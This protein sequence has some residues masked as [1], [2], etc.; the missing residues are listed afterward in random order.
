LYTVDKH[1]ELLHSGSVKW[2]PQQYFVSTKCQKDQSQWQQGLKHGP[3][4]ACLLRLRV[5][6][7]RTAWLSVSC[8]GCVLSGRGLCDGLITHPEE[9]YWVCCV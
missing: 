4:A 5:Q 7:P 1:F 2:S 8:E 9:S 3:E 6:I